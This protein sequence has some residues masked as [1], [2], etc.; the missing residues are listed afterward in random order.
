[1]LKPNSAVR[2]TL[3][4]GLPIIRIL[5]MAG[6]RATTLAGGRI[7]SFLLWTA[8]LSVGFQV[9]CCSASLGSSPSGLSRAEG[10]AKSGTLVSIDVREERFGAKCDWVDGR[11]TNDTPAFLKAAE[12]A[13]KSYRET[14]RA[15]EVHIGDACKLAS[16]VRFGSGVHWIGPGTL[17]VPHQTE[18]VLLAQDADDVAVTGLGIVVVSQ[19]CGTNNASCSAISWQASSMDRS[20]HRHVVFRDNRVEHS[21]WG[22]L[23][24]YAA[25]KG[26]LH[27]VEIRG[28]RVSSHRP[29]QDADGI[30]VGGRV[31]RFIVTGNRILNRG[32]AGIA[33]SSE[34]PDYI[35]SDG[36]IE[37][38]ALIEDQVGL[39]NS[40]CT[41][42]VWRGN[43]VYA[44]DTPR[45][46]NPAFRSIEYLGFS[47][48][49]VVV[50]GNYLKNSS[51]SGEYAAKVDMN[52]SL[53]PTHLSFQQNV[54]DSPLALYLRGSAIWVEAN[55][56]SSRHPTLTIDYNGPRSVKTDDV[57]IAKNIW[58][59]A[60][61]MQVGDNRNLL[62]HIFLAPQAAASPLTI[63][64]PDAFNDISQA[65]F[66]A[67]G[68]LEPKHRIFYIKED[69]TRPAG[70]G[71]CL[72]LDKQAPG[73]TTS[74]SIR[75]R[76]QDGAALSPKF[77][78][79]AFAK[80]RDR[81]LVKVC[82][83]QETAFQP[84]TLRV[85]VQ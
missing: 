63:T 49:H 6:R 74:N 57:T 64:H 67:T 54:V 48:D 5:I 43:V 77:V 39:D 1:M 11:G 32:D 4:E 85:D 20:D 37:D 16:V 8:C 34:V 73:L 47:P 71:D 17:F 9:Q 14:G 81:I 30:H 69:A 80:S 23:V 44:T 33:A 82:A 70:P 55:I 83:I 61:R 12:A 18:P 84:A 42:T 38:N 24:A 45:G 51:A 72:L 65:P 50:T 52:A 10:R 19:D 76:Q 25:G 3:L 46:S 7:R 56:F 66:R 79:W 21:N 28:N 41:N 15:V 59:G 2:R 62:S 22:I 26:S 36:V 27:D 31:R 75:V 13:S 53:V 35:C 58:L 40:G 78:Y 29:Y 60:G 68:R